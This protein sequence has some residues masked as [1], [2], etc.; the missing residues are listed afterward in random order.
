M[1]KMIFFNLPTANLP[2]ARALYE[3]VASMTLCSALAANK[4]GSSKS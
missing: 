4:T 1:I 2:R 3:L